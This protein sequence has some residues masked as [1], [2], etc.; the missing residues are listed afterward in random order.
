[1]FSS[2]PVKFKNWVFCPSAMKPS[3]PYTNTF[4]M[5]YIL[6]DNRQYFKLLLLY[7]LLMVTVGAEPSNSGTL[8]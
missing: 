3:G 5:H 7:W 4:D 6:G 8:I 1:M 2:S